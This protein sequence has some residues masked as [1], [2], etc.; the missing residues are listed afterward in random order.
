MRDVPT[1]REAFGISPTF[2]KAS[3]VQRKPENPIFQAGNASQEHYLEIVV[4]QREMSTA[5]ADEERRFQLALIAIADGKFKS[6]AA[7]ARHFYAKYDV[8]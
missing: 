4:N 7:A 3:E 5:T 6:F 8:L 2:P 1:N